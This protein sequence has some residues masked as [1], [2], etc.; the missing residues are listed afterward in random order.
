MERI[1]GDALP[2][3]PS[4]APDL[5]IRGTMATGLAYTTSETADTMRDDT[6]SQAS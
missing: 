4:Y 5:D 3:Q 1:L 6:A 2:L